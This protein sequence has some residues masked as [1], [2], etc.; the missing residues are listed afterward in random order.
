[1]LS[2]LAASASERTLVAVAENPST[3]G[4]TLQ[5]LMD[6]RSLAVRQTLAENP[7]TPPDVLEHLAKARGATSQ[8]LVAVAGNPSADPKTL[9]WLADVRS[10]AK[11]EILKALAGNRAS[12]TWTRAAIVRIDSL[13]DLVLRTAPSEPVDVRIGLTE[14]SYL[15]EKAVLTVLSHDKDDRVRRAVA[16]SRQADAS[17]LELLAGD[18]VHA[19]SSVARA[20]QITEPSELAR[21]AST[22]DRLVLAALAMN[23]NTPD[24]VKPEIARRL[25][26][27]A[28]EGTLRVLAQDQ[29]TPEDVLLQLAAHRN[30]SIRGAVSA[31]KVVTAETLR[32]L[33]SDAEVGI[34]ARAG[35]Y[36]QL[37][38]ESLVT[39]ATDA[40]TTVRAAVAG[41]PSTP[42]EI[43]TRLAS[44]AEASVVMAV[45]KNPSAT[46]GV[47]QTIVDH[48]GEQRH[49]VDSAS[50]IVLGGDLLAQ[51]AA[52]PRTPPEALQIL[53]D[54]RNSVRAAVA[55]NPSTPSHV[56]DELA[57]TVHEHV[58]LKGS[59]DM[60]RLDPEHE[61]DRILSA[62]VRNPSSS[63]GTL[64]FLSSGDWAARKTTTRSER[65]D[66]HTTRWTI[67]DP[68]ATEGAQKDKASW[69]RGEISRRQW[70][71]D[72][73]LPTRLRFATN[74][75]AAPAILADL[76]MDADDSVRSAVAA[77]RSTPHGAFM[78]LVGDPVA[79]VRIAA[80]TASH[81]PADTHKFHATLREELY[82][83]A[84]ERL[85]VDEVADVRAALVE[86]N[87]I[88]WRVLSAPV[89]EKLV[90]DDEI[91]VREALARSY[92]RRD[93]LGIWDALSP[94]SYGQLLDFRDVQVWREVAHDF[95]APPEVLERLVDLGDDEAA[96]AAVRR[97][98]TESEALA[99]L[100]GS[101]VPIVLAAIL[102]RQDLINAPSVTRALAANIATPPKD[103]ERLAR[104]AKDDETLTAAIRNPTFPEATLLQFASGSDERFLRAVQWCGRSE[105]IRRLA[106]NP[107]APADVLASLASVDDADVR[108]ALLVNKSTPADALLRLVQRGEASKS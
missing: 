25:V 35:G 16:I 56:L 105:P 50:R 76:A 93:R 47:L 53:A 66:G 97:I 9:K 52:N 96:A 77:N 33:A 103:L 15:Q 1:M 30:S 106:E 10:P 87:V 62:I 21:L 78:N 26:P 57:R 20:R 3:P 55:G 39:L 64:Q 23:A 88:F 79:E 5:A 11:M 18:E 71:G 83:D 24:A 95:H 82:R 19:V 49:G 32:L 7:A 44:D 81:P 37:P 14:L 102:S 98:D 59:P 36:A 4:Q 84:Y 46:S 29:A 90:F 86:N 92:L 17:L 99:R 42:P 61:R 70:R 67:W 75:D 63:L 54:S 85:A 38:L 45:A 13:R 43:L 108:E 27:G 68:K 94:R 107:L 80:A 91:P 74:G 58:W 51:V 101:A 60:K 41:N 8:T 104:Y 100:A 89:R 28:G 6:H 12:S 34:R 73:D 40:E 2:A 48:H 72:S 22:E 69:V 31:N 65:E